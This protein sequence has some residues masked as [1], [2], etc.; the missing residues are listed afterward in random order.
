MRE[1]LEKEEEMQE[2]LRRVPPSAPPPSPPPCAVYAC[3]RISGQ[4]QPTAREGTQ[5]KQSHSGRPASPQG[6]TP[7]PLELRPG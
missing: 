1:L 4:E 2:Y 3:G 5:G 7:N 6:R